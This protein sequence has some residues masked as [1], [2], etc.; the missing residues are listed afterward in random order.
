[1]EFLYMM[2]EYDWEEDTNGT[3]LLQEQND[4]K[5]RPLTYWS[6]TSADISKKLIR[7]YNTKDVIEF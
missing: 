6:K 3:V 1:M 4:S 7:Y 5:Q 2:R